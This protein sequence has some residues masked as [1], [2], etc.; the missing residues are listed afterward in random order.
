[1]RFLFLALLVLIGCK[2]R[3]SDLELFEEGPIKVNL[4]VDVRRGYEPLEVNFAGY[5]E[6]EDS[7][8]SRTIEDIKWLIREPNGESREVISEDFNY[9]DESDNQRGAFYLTQMFYRPGKYRVRL[10]LNEG[11]YV[12]SP[13]TIDVFQDPKLQ[14]RRY[15]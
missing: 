4:T 12:S 13:I 6:T 15:N 10:I 5:L 3:K 1:M 11:Q 14:R 8:I 2:E 7:S 9:Q